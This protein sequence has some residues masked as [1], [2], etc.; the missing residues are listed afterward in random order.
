MTTMKYILIF[1]LGCWAFTACSKAEPVMFDNSITLHDIRMLELRADHQTMFADGQAKMNLR[2][3]AYGIREMDFHVVDTVNDKIIFLDYKGLDTFVIPN[4]LIQKEWIKL[5]DDQGNLLKDNTFS[6]LD[7]TPRTVNFRARI[8]EL[9][10]SK[11]P[12]EIRETVEPTYEKIVYPV[13]FHVIVPAESAGVPPTVTTADL[14]KKL[15]RVNDIFNRRVTTDPNGGDARIT[16]ELAKFNPKGAPLLEP[17]KNQINLV[18]VLPD[19]KAHEEYI[20]NNAVWDSKKYLNIWIVN[21][22]KLTGSSDAVTD[23]RAKSPNVYIT[24]SEPIPGL[25]MNPVNDTWKPAEIYDVGVVVPY[26]RF[27][28]PASNGNDLFE[29]GTAIGS[30]LGL[31]STMVTDTGSNMID[32]DT[33]Y[34]PDTQYYLGGWTS[35]YKTN[36]WDKETVRPVVHFTSFNVM[37]AYSWKNSIS[38]D[39]ANRMRKVTERCPSRWSYKSK[40]ALTGQN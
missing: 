37:D 32:E 27:F 38:A 7:P 16:F 22:T 36:Q 20:W 8:G 19:F 26:T 10:S 13:I 3:I 2:A 6:T 4:D 29:L 24:G 9:E 17:G 5:Y 23:Y 21:V 39:Q 33:D 15:D 11:L 18:K 34:C 28:N 40:W 35:L 14:Q 30:Y 1:I 31:M 12:I 25:K